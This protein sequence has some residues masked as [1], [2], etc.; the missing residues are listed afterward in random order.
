MTKTNSPSLSFKPLLFLLRDTASAWNN[1][2][3]SRLAAALS[4]YTIFSIAP[5]LIIAIAISA[6][7][8]G[9]EAASNE[10]FEQIRGLVGDK[11]AQAIQAMVEGANKQDS[12]ILATVVGLAALLIGASG[13]FSQL[14]DSLNTIWNVKAKPGF[15]IKGMIWTRFLSFSMVL[16]IAFILLVSLVITAAMAALGHYLGALLPVP[17]FI[18]Q[19]ATFMIAFATTAVLFTVIFKVLPDVHIQW[20][21]V[22]IGGVVTSLLFSIGHLLIGL[23]LGHGSVG[24]TYG[25]AGSLIIILVRIYYS[26]VI[27]AEGNTK[28]SSRR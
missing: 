6:L 26:M 18:M 19:T 14:Q 7:V 15:G 3:A 20:K 24:P 22:W 27:V 23:Y 10:I 8:F 17:S 11:G 13:A 25:A 5:L 21:D 16:V 1:D 4:Y 2:H 12:G 28:A 9:Q